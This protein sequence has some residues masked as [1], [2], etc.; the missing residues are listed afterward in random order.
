MCQQ[1]DRVTCITCCIIDNLL[2]EQTVRENAQLLDTDGP[3]MDVIP[4]SWNKQKSYNPPTLQG[5]LI[6]KCI[7]CYILYYILVKKCG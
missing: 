5:G 2:R 3:N 7:L 6:Y 1:P 4:G